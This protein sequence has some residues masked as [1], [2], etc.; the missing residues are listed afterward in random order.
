M[1]FMLNYKSA[2]AFRQPH[3]KTNC[4]KKNDMKARLQKRHRRED[5][6]SWENA[7]CL[8]GRGLEVPGVF[9]SEGVTLWD[10]DK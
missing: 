9:D 4:K 8:L 10:V 6:F 1:Q 3:G 7:V 2:A 5:S